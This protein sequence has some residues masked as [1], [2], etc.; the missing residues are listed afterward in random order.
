MTPGTRVKDR[1]GHTGR[2]NRLYDDF[3]AIASCCQSLTGDEWFARQDPP[4]PESVKSEMWAE[5]LV[6]PKGSILSPV[7]LLTRL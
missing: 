5:V 4:L 2:I 7:S 3:S 6:E 1:H